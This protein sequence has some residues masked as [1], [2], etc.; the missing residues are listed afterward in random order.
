MY[1][2]VNDHI[3]LLKMCVRICFWAGKYV[4]DIHNLKF[5]QLKQ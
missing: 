3:E 1:I 4:R 5:N 2:H